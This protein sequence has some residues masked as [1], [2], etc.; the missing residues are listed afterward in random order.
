MFGKMLTKNYQLLEREIA[1]TF[2]RRFTKFGPQPEASL[3]FSEERQRAR[4]SIIADIIRERIQ[5][6]KVSI[7]DIGCGYGG[8][9]KFLQNEHNNIDFEYTGYDLADNLIE[10]CDRKMSSKNARFIQGSRPVELM[11]FSIM[12][13]TYNYAPQ[14]TVT[15]W[16]SYFRSE[17]ESIFAKTKKCLILN[18]MIADLPRISK[19]GI[20]YEELDDFK[21]FCEE[22]LGAVTTYDHVLLKNETTFCITR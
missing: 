6:R 19:S 5:N 9:L 16:R 7:C 3:W 8:F 4:F 22:R 21:N 10:F 12:S 17:L 2:S 11:D 14:T 18:L 13:G 15:D 20:F 1:S